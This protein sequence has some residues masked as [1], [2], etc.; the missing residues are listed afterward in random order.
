MKKRTLGISLQYV[1]TLLNMACGLFLSSFLLRSLG[2]T[3]YGLYQT[4]SSFVN[5]LV[6]LEFGTGTVITRNISACRARDD[7]SAI[8]KN[9]ST[10]LAI[11]CA[12]VGVIVLTG[13]VFYSLFDRIYSLSLTPEQIRY[14]KQIFLVMLAFLI[15]SYYANTINGILLGFEKYEM[16]PAISIVRL[17]LRTALLVVTVLSVRKAIVIAFVDLALSMAVDVFLIVYCRRIIGVRFHFRDVDRAVFK[18]SLPLA[19]AIFLQ[20]LINQANN[21]VD[22]FVIGIKLGPED[23]T[24][25]SLGLYVYSIFSAL[26]TIPISMYGPQVVKEIAGGSTPNEVSRHLIQPSRLI[27]LIGGSILFG[28]FAVGRQFIT[29]LYGSSYLIAWKVALII[30]APMLVNMSTGIMIN[31][32]D[33]TDKR[34]AR[35]GLLFLTTAA[36][37]VLTVIWIDK[38]G[39]L[40]ACI[41]TAVCTMLGHVILMDIYYYDR[42][43]IRILTFKRETCRGILV[44]QIAAGAIGFFAGTR[45]AHPFTSFLAGGI[46]YV[47][48]FCFLFFVYGANETEKEAVRK[49]LKRSRES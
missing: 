4:V 34:M 14:G 24:V 21:N 32:L 6:L 48:C 38:Y 44:C 20:V 9:V 26:T 18:S 13:L 46:A 49:R 11:S 37:I 33:A 47:V 29:L 35:S 7:D 8:Q 16:P 39:I 30:M 15:V 10:V 31:I 17:L 25:Y 19:T 43:K 2:D 42:L 3:E 45:I 1:N 40:G 22:K 12:L 41:A 36:N 23:V 5:Y 28:F 27:V